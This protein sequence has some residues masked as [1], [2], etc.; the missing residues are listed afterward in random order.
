M[1]LCQTLLT[2]LLCT[3]AS[4]VVASSFETE[5]W[6]TTNGAHVVFYQAMEVPMLDITLAFAAGSA[7]DA[8][9]FGLSALTTRLLNQGNGGFNADV[10]AERLAE[11]GAQYEASNNQDMQVFNLKTLTEPQ[12]LKKAAE[13]FTDIINHPDFPNDAFY[14]EKNQQLMAIAEAQESPDE[15]ANQ[16]F[17]QILYQTHPYAHPI[18]GNQNSVQRLMLEHVRQF[19]QRFFV[20]KNT[21]IVLVGAID[22][23]EAKRLAE[24]IVGRLPAGRA[25][26]PIPKAPSLTEEINIEI[27]FAS[28]QTVLRLGQIGINH[29]D[30]D[31]FPLLVGNYILGGNPLGSELA[32]ELREKRGLTY[33]VQSQFAPMPGNGPFIISLSTKNS[34]TK[35]AI[36]VVHQTLSDFI[37]KGPT[38][39]ELLAA[40]QYL[41]GSY[42]LSLASNRSI[43]TMLLK[44]AFY[45][46]PKDYLHTYIAR[47]NAVQAIEIKNA[48]KQHITQDKLLQMTVGRT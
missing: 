24:Q 12:A 20:G 30:P 23:S 38:E 40:K 25:A 2:M 15:I 35:T 44:I 34:Q 42:P 8:Q 17:F 39:T 46:L 5:E 22:K 16:T 1:N 45:H 7:Y 3:F 32:D 13:T 10:I 33:G 11:T 14:H 37:K 36:D 21:V 6:E 18:I 26:P 4:T 27:P 47:I 19:Y 43:A 48:F 29:H 9:Q 31:F 41:T 28:S